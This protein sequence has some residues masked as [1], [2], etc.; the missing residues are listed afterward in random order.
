M[1]HIARPNIL[2]KVNIINMITT[3]GIYILGA[4]VGLLSLVLPDYQLAAEPMSALD[5][6]INYILAWN[7]I[8]PTQTLL[9]CFY[10][11]IVFEITLITMRLFVG[12]V[13]LFRGSGKPEI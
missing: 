2:K 3:I 9:K 12:L 7:N 1:R 11:M 13:A 5:D 4:L 8:V 10:W 6:A